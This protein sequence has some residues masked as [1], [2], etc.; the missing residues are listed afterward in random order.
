MTTPCSFCR[1]PYHEATGHRFSNGSVWCGPCTRDFVDWLR[2]NKWRNFYDY[3]FTPEEAVRRR[4]A[5][6][7]SADPQ[8]PEALPE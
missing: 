5:A 1:G 4:L 2:R 6:T 8:Y 3:A 7:G